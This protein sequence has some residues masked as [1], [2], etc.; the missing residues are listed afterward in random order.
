MSEENQ[1]ALVSVRLSV[2]MFL[3]FFI[4]GAWYVTGP[5]YLGPL[6]FE[7]ADFAN[8]YSVGPLSAMITPLLVGMVADRFFAVE[9]VL[10]V[11]H[12]GA[13][14]AMLGAIGLMGAEDPNP[15]LINLMFLVHML[16]YFPTLAL[17]NTLAMRNMTD[18][19]KQFPLIRV[20]GTVGWIIAGLT[21]SWFVWD[22]S[23]SMFYLAAGA[24][25]A[26]GFYSFTLPHTPPVPGQERPTIGQLF[27]L[28]AMAMLKRPAFAV[29]MVSSILICIPLAFYYQ[30]A[31]K[32]VQQTGLVPGR[33]MS[34]GQ[35]SEILFM[36]LMPLFFKR[37]GVKWMLFVGM[38][39]WV[40]RYALF[41]VGAPDQVVWMVLVGVQ[42]HGI[43]YD[44]FFVTGQIYTDKA[45]PK[46]IRG[47][48]QGMLVLFTLGLGMLIGARVAGMVEGA[49][50]PKKVSWLQEESKVIGDHASQ[51]QAKLDSQAPA[52]P[53]HEQVEPK[54]AEVDKAVFQAQEALG[55]AKDE[56]ADQAKIDALKQE[57]AKALDRK[58]EILQAQS[59]AYGAQ[60]EQTRALRSQTEH[61][62]AYAN[63]KAIAA[64][65]LVDWR[66]IW[67]WPAIGAA[68]V[69]IFFALLFKDRRVSAEPITEERVA[70]AAAK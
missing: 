67:M 66:G 63:H 53:F 48:A 16:F 57:V 20:F 29:F 59:V 37:L 25:L 52:K 43:C 23:K 32:V 2:M 26:M 44:F 55:E 49:Y 33:T 3:Q 11:M 60:D 27:G 45:A 21:I 24:A 4:W 70:E 42:L 12:L 62:K 15:D 22:T 18:Q 14:A 5:L 19:E 34:Y 64:L 8:M 6:G 13:G 10:G 1:P 17:T 40:A 68:V 30:I 58:I 38:A 51:L 28:D 41:A 39:A 54:V 7:P 36:L 61:L 46:A 56:G 50:T 69:M 35:M 47:Q 9:R 65:R 31:A